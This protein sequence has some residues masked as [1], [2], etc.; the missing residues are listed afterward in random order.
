MNHKQILIAEDNRDH[1][2]I[3]QHQLHRIGTFDIL[4]AIT[5]RT[6]WMS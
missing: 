3:L 1:R 4:E 2:L 5:D 6:H